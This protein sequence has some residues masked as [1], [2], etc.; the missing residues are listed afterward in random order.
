MLDLKSFFTDP[1]WLNKALVHKSY[2]NEHPGT[3]S[4]ERLEFLGDSVLSLVIS[5]RLFVLFP[6]APEGE[7]TTRR[8]LLVQTGSLY[9]KAKLL[10]LNNL[11]QLSRGE[12]DT[13]G[14]SNIGL[15]ANTFEAIL[16]A[17][18]MDGGLDAC[19]K[20]LTRVFPDSELLADL[21]LKD[22]KSLLQE[23]SQAAGFGTP[24][25]K[26]V[27]SD[28]PDH[29]R[30]FVIEAIIDNKPAGTG[31]GSSKQKAETQAA[32]SALDNLFPD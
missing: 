1:F 9:E 19:R 13:G 30:N 28:G 3:S 8:S 15:L 27:S 21:Q 20:Y 5:E 2:C 29:A 16:G 17:M 6:Q 11:L 12:E 25:Y 32:S 14:R 4:N 18:F 31:N 7:L 10:K 26:L 22:P 23:K 24:L